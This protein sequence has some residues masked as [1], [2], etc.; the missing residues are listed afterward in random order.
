MEGIV[1]REEE[2]LRGRV[3]WFDME[4][5]VGVEDRVGVG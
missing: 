2:G 3:V 1:E 4:K 5:I